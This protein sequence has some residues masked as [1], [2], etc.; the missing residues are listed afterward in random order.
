MK[1]QIILDS[2]VMYEFTCVSRNNPRV[3]DAPDFA[4]YA[5]LRREGEY[6]SRARKDYYN[7]T[8]EAYPF[9]STMKKAVLN[10]MEKKSMAKY[11]DDFVWLLDKLGS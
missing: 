1:K 2:G 9:Q 4:H 3:A 7:R 8:W 5:T 11:A 10:A 6:I